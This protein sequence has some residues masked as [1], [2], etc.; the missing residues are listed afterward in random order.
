MVA[1][2]MQQFSD[3]IHLLLD[4]LKLGFAV[5]RVAKLGSYRVLMD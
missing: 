3:L 5:R 1:E 4:A 2:K